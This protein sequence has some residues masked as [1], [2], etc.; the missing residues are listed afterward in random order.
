MDWSTAFLI[1][2]V[3]VGLYILGCA[4]LVIKGVTTFAPLRFPESPMYI[5]ILAVILGIASFG[6]RTFPVFDDGTHTLTLGPAYGLF[7]ALLAP[8]SVSVHRWLRI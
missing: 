3:G 5:G 4:L 7:V 6:S 1:A 2:L 8:L